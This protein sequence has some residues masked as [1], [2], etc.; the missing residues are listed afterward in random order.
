MNEIM[1]R[2]FNDELEKISF[3][4]PFGLAERAFKRKRLRSFVTG[5]NNRGW[6]KLGPDG[7]RLKTNINPDSTLNLTRPFGYKNPVVRGTSNAAQ[8][9]LA[10]PAARRAAKVVASEFDPSQPGFLDLLG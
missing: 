7:K 3:I 6:V 9:A 5:L 1:L 2:A 10:S 4:I 8:V